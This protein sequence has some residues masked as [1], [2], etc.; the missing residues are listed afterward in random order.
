MNEAVNVSSIRRSY[1]SI[2][3]RDSGVY[4]CHSR[5]V[6]RE[7][8]PPRTGSCEAAGRPRRVRSG[9]RLQRRRLVTGETLV[10]Q[11][12]SSTDMF[13]LPEGVLDV[14]IDGDSVAQVGSGA[15]LGELAVLGDGTRT[16]TL[17]VVRPSR[18]AV[19]TPTHR[20]AELALARRVE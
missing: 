4:R 15:V 18:V 11:G 10:E 16:A 6:G 3:S 14:E 13:L 12:E 2:A 7:G 5:R 8:K 1:S 20:L 19:L 17:R 9:A